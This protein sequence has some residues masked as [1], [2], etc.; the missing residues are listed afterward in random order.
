MKLSELLRGIESCSCGRAHPCPIKHVIIEDG[1]IERLSE[2]AG[3]YS[4]ILVIA[5]NN[6]YRVAGERVT[7]ALGE[8]VYDTLIFSDGLLVPNE[9]AIDKINGRISGSCDLIVGIGS[10]VIN[11]LA[12][13]TS[14]SHS[15][16]Y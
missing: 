6:T 13:Y 10:G 14:H 2:I 5:D 7:S 3:E 12:K 1:A 4:S 11:D 8:R 16:P 9:D 15:L